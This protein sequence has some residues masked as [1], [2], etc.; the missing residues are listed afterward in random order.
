MKFV[1]KFF[2]IALLLCLSGRSVLAM[3]ESPAGGPASVK[4]GAGHADETAGAGHGSE[5][6][7]DDVPDLVPDTEV[8]QDGDTTESEPNTDGKKHEEK[9]THPDKDA[10][11][12][13][14]E[15]KSSDADGSDKDNSKDKKD[16]IKKATWLKSLRNGIN[17]KLR[18]ARKLTT[19]NPKTAVGIGGLA[20]FSG[21]YGFNQKFKDTVKGAYRT[22]S[23]KVSSYVIEPTAKRLGKSTDFVQRLF[24]GAAVTTVGLVGVKKLHDKYDLKQKAKDAK[25]YV[26]SLDLAT[27]KGVARNKNVQVGTAFVVT[28]GLV[29][30]VSWKLA[31]KNKGEQPKAVDD[32]DA[33]KDAGLES[34]NWNELLGLFVNQITDEQ[35]ALDG[36]EKLLP[37]AYDDPTVLV[38]NQEFMSVL[39]ANQKDMVSLII[40]LYAEETEEPVTEKAESQEKPESKRSDAATA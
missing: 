35:W 11:K 19:D 31:N 12:D 15:K 37:A 14:K 10:E 4:A 6:D 8:D 16:K 17:N 2:S 26:Q 33:A 13:K 22:V 34:V 9:K 21:L 40:K 20:V 27:I 18:S 28:S 3:D 38:K 5:S 7:D 29:G 32:L 36:I 23:E 24:G 39:D 25:A 1:N 30:Y